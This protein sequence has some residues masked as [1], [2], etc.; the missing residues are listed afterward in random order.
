[1]NNNQNL[2]NK[3]NKLFNKKQNKTINK[4]N[5]KNKRQNKKTKIKLKVTAIVL[6]LWKQKQNYNI[7][8]KIMNSNKLI[9]M[10]YLIFESFRSYSNSIFHN[11]ANR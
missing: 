6:V 10:N 5:N 4:Q 8:N 7:K 1:M 3:N 11:I 2:I 9:L